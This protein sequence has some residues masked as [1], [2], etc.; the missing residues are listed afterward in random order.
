MKRLLLIL[1]A[2]CGLAA[3]PAAP[4]SADTVWDLREGT[5]RGYSDDPS[6]NGEYRVWVAGDRVYVSEPKDPEGNNVPIESG[7][8]AS[9]FNNMGLTTEFHC[10]KA[11]I[12][13][14]VIE[15]GPGEDS[16]TYEVK[17]IP[18]SL[19][20]GT[21]TEKATSSDA[22]DDLSGE[23]GNDTLTSGAGDDI[24]NGDEGNDTLDAGPGNDKVVGGAGTDVIAAG[25]GDDELVTA[26]GLAETVDCGDGTDTITADVQDKLT[27]CENVTTQNIT[28]VEEE[29]AGNDT[30]RPKV[31]YGGSGRQRAGSGVRFV[32]TC[33]EKGIVQAAGYVDSGGI[34]HAL[35]LVERK[36]TVGGGGAVLKLKFT[37]RIKRSVRNDLRKRR[38]PRVRVTLSCVDVAGNTSRARKFWIKLKR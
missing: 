8:Q 13:S 1:A 29:P 14:L 11:P 27:G 3:L 31:D 7:C 36:L 24:V 12:T 10:P 2:A 21:G 25:A 37:S 33:T 6:I 30:T 22:G 28:G 17:D 35:K 18:L 38:T 4:A 26:D 9:K 16:V 23:Q 5:L 20:G 32:A 19:A 15:G 34:N